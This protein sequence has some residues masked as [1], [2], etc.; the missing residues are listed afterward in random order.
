MLP[1]GISFEVVLWFSLLF[2]ACIF[3]Y[4]FTTS[5][6]DGNSQTNGNEGVSQLRLLSCFQMTNLRHRM[7]ELE[8]YGKF[9]EEL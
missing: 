8:T 4:C 1:D 5:V 9:K 2:Q 7:D 6:E 3:S